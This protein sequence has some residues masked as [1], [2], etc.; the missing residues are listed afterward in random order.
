MEMNGASLE[1]PIL[2]C[3]GEGYLLWRANNGEHLF[4]FKMFLLSRSDRNHFIPN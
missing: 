2:T 3:I 4:V 1:G